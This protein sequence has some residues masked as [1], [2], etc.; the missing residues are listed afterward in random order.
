MVGRDG[1][2][3]DEGAVLIYYDIYMYRQDLHNFRWWDDS[4]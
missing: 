3:L 1:I 2:L 4:K